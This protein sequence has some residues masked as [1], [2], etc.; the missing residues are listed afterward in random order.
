M[1]IYIDNA[2][3]GELLKN[4]KGAILE[5][6]H[7]II[8]NP[9]FA[10]YGIRIN[11]CKKSHHFDSRQDI[12][13]KDPVLVTSIPKEAHLVNIGSLWVFGSNMSL[14]DW[15]KGAADPLDTKL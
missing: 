13:L 4:V 12:I 7:Q 15:L 9:G 8:E 14:T 1:H 2:I 3:Q 11:G 10:S 5:S 6:G